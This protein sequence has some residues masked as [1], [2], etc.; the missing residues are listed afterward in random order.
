MLLLK[1]YVCSLD[2]AL[3]LADLSRYLCPLYLQLMRVQ[4][5]LFRTAVVDRAGDCNSAFVGPFWME[6][7]VPDC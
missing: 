3:R 1:L 7:N 4:Y 6:L 2:A 5:D